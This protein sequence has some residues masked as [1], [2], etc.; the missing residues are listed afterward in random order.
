[1]YLELTK[2]KESFTEE[3]QHGL[4]VYKEIDEID[5]DVPIMGIYYPNTKWKGRVTYRKG[6]WMLNNVRNIIGDKN[7][8]KFTKNIYKDFC[9]RILTYDGFKKYLSKYDKDGSCII[10]SDK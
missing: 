7:W 4:N 2:G 9:G 1:M 8:E 6:L 3:L 10:K 5:K